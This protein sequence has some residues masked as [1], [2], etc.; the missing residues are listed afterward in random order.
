M[1]GLM[2]EP[3]LYSKIERQF[4]EGITKAQL[5]AA[6]RKKAMA[7]LSAHFGYNVIF[8]QP[9]NWIGYISRRIKELDKEVDL[10]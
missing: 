4:Y 7:E 3:I 2:S 10:Q 9:E 5:Y 1:G 6:L 8:D